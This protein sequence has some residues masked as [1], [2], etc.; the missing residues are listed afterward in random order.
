M[1]RLKLFGEEPKRL[2]LFSEAPRKKLFSSED[3]SVEVNG[4]DGIKLHDLICQDC[5]QVITTAETPTHATCPNCGG[6]RMIFKLFPTE[7][8]V[9]PDLQ[10]HLQEE[11]I[12]KG[13][14]PRKSLFENFLN[15]LESKL[16]EFSGK[17]I[18][19]ETFEKT[20]SDVEAG[21]LIER[22]YAMC[23]S[24]GNYS[25]SDSA[26]E[27]EK[28]FSKLIISVTKTLELDPSIMNG[29]IKKEDIIDK[30]E[31][32]EDLPEK[33]I[34]ALKKAHGIPVIE[35]HEYSDDEQESWLEDSSIVPDLELEYNNQ[36]FGIEQFIKIIRDRYP[37][38]PENIL[39]LLSQV[40][41]IRIDGTQVNIESRK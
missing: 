20:F 16:K 25:I 10:E 36:S 18:D 15:P 23:D 14:T 39:D 3:E 35:E 8:V 28:T 24:E 5:G 30:L 7:N 22:N 9:E 27:I 21:K 11:K 12:E 19:K 29:D 41:T 32:H 31:E 13:E 1:E 37:D 38:A 40:G 4:T 6:K 17:T 33:G 26:F 34:I 2:K